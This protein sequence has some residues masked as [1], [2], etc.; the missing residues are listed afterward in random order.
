MSAELD[1]CT[2][3]DTHSCFLDLVST[4]FNRTCLTHYTAVPFADSFL[5]NILRTSIMAASFGYSIGTMSPAHSSFLGIVGASFNRTYLVPFLL[6]FLLIILHRVT[7]S[8]CSS[9]NSR[10]V[11]ATRCVWRAG[12]LLLQLFF[13]A[14]AAAALLSCTV[15]LELYII[16]PISSSESESSS[17]LLGLFMLML[18]FA[19][20]ETSTLSIVGMFLLVCSSKLQS[21]DSQSIL[22]QVGQLSAAFT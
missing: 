2:M 12:R 20:E 9:S 4:S 13:A 22:N 7:L 8:F 17:E 15:L 16:R 18:T 14:S 3:P 1:L 21:R 10:I 11:I 6:L 5:N 19:E